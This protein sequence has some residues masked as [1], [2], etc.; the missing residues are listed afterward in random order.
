[1]IYLLLQFPVASSC[2]AQFPSQDLNLATFFL[3]RT[4]VDVVFASSNQLFSF[5]GGD[6]PV[7]SQ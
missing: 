7:S 5:L 3:A 2:R 4:V 1:M 6:I